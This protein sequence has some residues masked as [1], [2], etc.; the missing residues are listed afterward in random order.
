VTFEQFDVRIIRPRPFSYSVVEIQQV[1]VA[2]ATAWVSFPELFKRPR[3][4]PYKVWPEQK[5]AVLNTPVGSGGPTS[6]Y[7]RRL[8]VAHYP[9]VE[10]HP[11]D[12][13][14]LPFVVVN[15]IIHQPRESGLLTPT[16]LTGRSAQPTLGGLQG[17]PNLSGEVEN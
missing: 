8:Y 13:R 9:P 3:A 4:V 2:P 5:V 16:V 11:F 7:D 15:I 1:V 6:F 17:Q 10:L 14:G 12:G